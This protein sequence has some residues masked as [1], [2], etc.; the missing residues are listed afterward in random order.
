MD[1]KFNDLK[2][3]NDSFGQELKT[4]IDGVMQSGWYIKGRQTELFEGEFA[5][6]VGT[7]YCIGTGNGLDALSLILQTWKEMYGWTD[8]DEVIVPS[9]TFVA[10]VLAISRIGL[11]PVFCDVNA[12]HALIDETLIEG[13]VTYRTRAIMPV[14]LYGRMCNMDAILEI[15][16]RH[17]LKVCEDACQAHGAIYSSSIKMDLTSMF[18]NRAGSIGDAAAF[19]FYPGK[20]LGCLGDGGCITT[21]NADEAVVMRKM[22]NYGQSDKYVHELK[23]FNSRLDELQ[24]AV[25][26]V[27]LRRLDK[28]NCRR[29]EL[30]KYYCENIHNEWIKL[31]SYEHDMSNVYHVFPIRCKNRDNLWSCLRSHGVETLIHYPTPVHRQQAYKEHAFLHLP[32]SEGWAAEEL[33]LPMNCILKDEEVEYVVDCLNDYL[34]D[35]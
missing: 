6:Y 28:D 9:H 34:V 25:L 14:H 7:K 35:Q 8:G 5:E 20:N 24:A 12:V 18:G 21:N 23:G 11:R 29:L 27:K 22:A 19:S 13:L 26:R 17:G 4:A 30:A 33:S 10:T 2:R 1:I 3:V 31:P 15:A 32:I 16:H